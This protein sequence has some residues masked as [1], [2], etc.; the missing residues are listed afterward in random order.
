MAH[1]SRS[2]AERL[3][4]DELL[5]DEQHPVVGAPQHVVPGSAVP[6]PGDRP[7]DGDVQGVACARAAGA[8]ERDVHVI[9]E[10]GGKRD[11]PA[12]PELGDRA[13]DVRVVEV[14]EI[15]EDRGYDV[16]NV[17]GGYAAYVVSIA[18]VLP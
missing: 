4:P 1:D 18:A 14:A 10:E 2:A 6:E 16:Y 3:A 7:D 5:A 9:A 13:R 11:V 8:P 17:E 15:L 12:P